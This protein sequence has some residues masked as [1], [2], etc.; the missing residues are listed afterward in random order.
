MKSLL[1]VLSRAICFLLYMV[2]H[3]L[4]KIAMF[5]LKKNNFKIVELIVQ[6]TAILLR[7]PTHAVCCN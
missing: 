1:L 5:F 6:V 2:V 7:P 3:F 4:V